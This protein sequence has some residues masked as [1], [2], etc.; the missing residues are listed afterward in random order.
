VDYGKEHEGKNL[1]MK[2]KDW[3]VKHSVMNDSDVG[4]EMGLIR[5]KAFKVVDEKNVVYQVI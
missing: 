3:H 2:N 1:R 5:N 4:K